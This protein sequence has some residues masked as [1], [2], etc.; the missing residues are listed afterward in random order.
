MFGPAPRSPEAMKT[1]NTDGRMEADARYPR[2][3]RKY[4]RLLP[5]WLLNLIWRVLR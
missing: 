4:G 2:W 5:N 1:W 3:L